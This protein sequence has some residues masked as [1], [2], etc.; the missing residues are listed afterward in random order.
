MRGADGDQPFSSVSIRTPVAAGPRRSRKAFAKMNAIDLA[1]VRAWSQQHG[2]ALSDR[3]LPAFRDANDCSVFDIPP[4]AGRRVAMVRGH[5]LAFHEEDEICVWLYDWNVWPSGQWHH[6][7]ERFRLS[8]G[9]SESLD[10]KPGHLI[11]KSDSAAASSIVTYA[12]LMLWDCHVLGA[13]GHPFLFYSHDEH[14][15]S[16]ANK[17]MHRTP[18]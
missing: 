16:G 13:S 12:V 9:V 18:R 1:S 11:A 4:D 2:Y 10:S 15:K 7:F 8:Y 6:T 17:Q 3:G 5:L 14:G